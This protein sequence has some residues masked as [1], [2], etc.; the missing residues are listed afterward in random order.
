MEIVIP[1]IP[2]W[3]SVV[4]YIIT[5]SL[6]TMV[7]KSIIDHILNKKKND[8]EI[9]GT[10]IEN[11]SKIDNYWENRFKGLKQDYEDREKYHNGRYEEL[12]T[13]YEEKYDFKNQLLEKTKRELSEITDLLNAKIEYIKKCEDTICNKDEKIIELTDQVLRLSGNFIEAPVK[14]VKSLDNYLL[15]SDSNS[16]IEKAEETTQ[17]EASPNSNINKQ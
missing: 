6:G 9:K 15:S 13:T 14:E 2:A 17:V 3:V 5:G 12:K 7:I 10:S 8:A 16:Q 1:G 4:L 11:D